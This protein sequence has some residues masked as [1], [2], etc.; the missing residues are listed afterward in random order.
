MPSL[1][2]ALESFNRRE[3][4][5]LV[6]WV[7]D[8]L[9]FPLGQ[10]FR[11]ALSD[12]LGTRVPADAYVAMDYNLN[13]LCAAL[14]WHEGMVAPDMP[15]LYSEQDGV[16]LSDN[17]DT[18]LIVAFARGHQTHVVLLEAKGYTKWTGGQLKNKVMRLNTVFG[19]TGDRFSQVI[20]YWVFVSPKPPSKDGLADWMLDDSGRPRHLPLPQP[21]HHKWLIARCDANGKRDSTGGHWRISSDPWPGR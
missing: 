16:E 20:P 9:T 8:R 14:M 19:A 10:E 18:D 11:L 7:L 15:H 17:S 5:I 4:H 13:W 3:R 21:A 12:N 2:D 1:L 6:G